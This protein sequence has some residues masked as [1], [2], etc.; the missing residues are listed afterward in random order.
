MKPLSIRFRGA[1]AWLALLVHM[2]VVPAYAQDTL[3]RLHTSHGPI[4]FRLL[5]GEAP[6]SVGNFLGYV[7][8]GDYTDVLFH[9]SLRNFVVEG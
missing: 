5:D 7:R 9:R 2:A 4:D 1:F 6:I 8:A 3:V